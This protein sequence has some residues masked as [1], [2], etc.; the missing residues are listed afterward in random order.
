M[1]SFADYAT[2][3]T[4]G[5]EGATYG[6]YRCDATCTPSTRLISTARRCVICRFL[7]GERERRDGS[8]R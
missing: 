4:L 1:A 3:S 7:T 6:G 8:R 5:V 2:A